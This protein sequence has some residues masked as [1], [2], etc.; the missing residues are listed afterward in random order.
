M[1]NNTIFNFFYYSEGRVK[2]MGEGKRERERKLNKRVK[3]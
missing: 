1:M 3:K 2:K